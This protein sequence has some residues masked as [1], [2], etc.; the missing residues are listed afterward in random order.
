MAGYSQGAMLVHRLLYKLVVKGRKG[1][2]D[3]VD[4]AALIADGDRIA[5]SKVNPILGSPAA[6]LGGQGVASTLGKLRREMSRRSC[7]LRR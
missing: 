1:I 5:N 4:G 7:G 2:L 6:G 3:R